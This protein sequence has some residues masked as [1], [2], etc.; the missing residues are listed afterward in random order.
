[1]NENFVNQGGQHFNFSKF[2]DFS[3]TFPEN[4]PWIWSRGL[5][6]PDFS[7]QARPGRHGYNL[8]PAR[9]EVKKK[10]SARARPGS[11]EKLNFRSQSGPARKGNWNFGP[12]PARP[13]RKIEISARARPG[14]K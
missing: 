3:L 6:G 10:I 12:S 5:H 2:S 14:L 9:P 7:V 8:G 4:F 11:K 13:E 1:M